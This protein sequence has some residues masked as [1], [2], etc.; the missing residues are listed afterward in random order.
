MYIYGSEKIRVKVQHTAHHH[1]HEGSHSYLNAKNKASHANRIYNT[2]KIS[3]FGDITKDTHTTLRKTT[4][5]NT[6]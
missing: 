5:I 6:L 3:S 1:C 2:T 4:Q